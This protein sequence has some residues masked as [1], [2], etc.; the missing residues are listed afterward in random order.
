MIAK[1]LFAE[2]PCDLPRVMVTVLEMLCLLYGTVLGHELR[3][4]GSDMNLLTEC[5]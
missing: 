5:P 1:S 3:T 4:P 2:S